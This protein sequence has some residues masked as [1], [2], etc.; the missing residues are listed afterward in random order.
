MIISEPKYKYGQ[1]EQITV[2][3]EMMKKTIFK[4]VGNFSE[5]VFI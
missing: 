5:N 1:Q 4:I 3:P 2:H